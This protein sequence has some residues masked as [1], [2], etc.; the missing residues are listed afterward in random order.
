VRA[1][2][3]AAKQDRAD[4]SAYFA[5]STYRELVP[6]VV[7]DESRSS[8]CDGDYVDGNWVQRDASCVDR[9]S[10]KTIAAPSD[11]ITVRVDPIPSAR[12]QVGITSAKLKLS[13]K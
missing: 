1:A 12:A 13:G 2:A 10:Y 3:S 7:I 6:R 9:I 4:T 8:F 5:V 11:Y